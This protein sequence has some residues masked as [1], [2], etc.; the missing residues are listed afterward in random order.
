MLPILTPR[1]DIKG[2]YSVS[3][4]TYHISNR[5]IINII[6]PRKN[7]NAGKLNFKEAGYIE[8]K[9]NAPKKLHKVS[10]DAVAENRAPEINNA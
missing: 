9:M 4:V 7:T 5:G 3:V 8:L 1:S 6:A 2:T 10:S